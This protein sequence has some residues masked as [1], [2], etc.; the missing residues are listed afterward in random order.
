MVKNHSYAKAREQKSFYRLDFF[1]IIIKISSPF[2]RNSLP[3][4]TCLSVCLF[5]CQ[6]QRVQIKYRLN[7]ES[8]N[9]AFREKR[10]QMLIYCITREAKNYNNGIVSYELEWDQ[11]MRIDLLELYTV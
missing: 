4:T 2:K 5:Y 9:Q 10:G 11:Q 3:F 1:F 7:T 6:Y 8:L